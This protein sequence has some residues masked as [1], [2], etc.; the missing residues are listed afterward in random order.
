MR[1]SGPL[2]GRRMNLFDRH[3]E[4]CGCRKC[5]YD[6]SLSGQV[7]PC[8]W[9]L[10]VNWSQDDNLAHCEYDTPEDIRRLFG[11][12]NTPS[13]EDLA[14]GQREMAVLVKRIEGKQFDSADDLH[15]YLRHTLQLSRDFD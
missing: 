15:D 6:V 1:P 4:T 5:V 8:G 7:D 2:G 14:Y 10:T 9:R 12:S 3:S 13:A 11:N